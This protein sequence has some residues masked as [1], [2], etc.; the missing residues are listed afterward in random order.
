MTISRYESR[1]LLKN[2]KKLYKQ[3]FEKRDVKFINHF[4]TANLKYPTPE[5]YGELEVQEETWKL[6]DR[7]YK[8]ADKYY[9]LASL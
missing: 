1:R 2:D 5:Q 3:H 9:N 8:Y 6:G 4:S 7:Y